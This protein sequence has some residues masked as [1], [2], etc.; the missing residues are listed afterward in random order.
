MR[1][2]SNLTYYNVTN[3][4]TR[5]IITNG[6]LPRDKRHLGSPF[7]SPPPSPLEILHNELLKQS[8]HHHYENTSTDLQTR[9]SPYEQYEDSP[10]ENV[11]LQAQQGP[12]P[13]SPRTRIKTFI[14][15]NKD[16]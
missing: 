3:V 7:G 16:R 15:A 8:N 14:S 9:R 11:T 6:S 10:Y 2:L 1:I 4:S 13:P 5:R 12:Y